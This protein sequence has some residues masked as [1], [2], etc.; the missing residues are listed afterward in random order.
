[1]TRDPTEGV[2]PYP[3]DDGTWAALV[4]IDGTAWEG[5]GATPREA[6]ERLRMTLAEEGD[7]R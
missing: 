6:L 3:L 7:E 4:V 5:Y 1:M 2:R